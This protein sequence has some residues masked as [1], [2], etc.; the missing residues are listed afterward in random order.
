MPENNSMSIV[1][2]LKSQIKQEQQRYRNALKSSN[3]F[4]ELKE[5]KNN[6]EKLQETLLRMMNNLKGNSS[7]NS[8]FQNGDQ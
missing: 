6:L 7:P 3:K 2:R 5:I 4:W 1:E 8:Q